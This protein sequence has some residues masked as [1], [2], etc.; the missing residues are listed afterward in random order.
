MPRARKQRP[1]V[2]VDIGN[3]K[4]GIFFIG[5]EHAITVVGVD[6]DIGDSLQPVFAA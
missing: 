5:I 1:P 4:F 6:I 2:L 3:K